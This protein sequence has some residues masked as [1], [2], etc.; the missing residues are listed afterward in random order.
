MKI[1][2]IL[3]LI[4][5]VLI[6]CKKEST[7]E[8]ML[9]EQPDAPLI[10][11]LRNGAFMPGPYGNVSGESK[12]YQTGMMYQLA[13]TNFLTSNGPDLKVYLSKELQ[14]V[15]FINLGSLKAISGNQLY[16]IP[17]GVNTAEYKY[18]LIY[19]QQYSHLFGSAELK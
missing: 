13:L 6:G 17:A 3:L 12:I 8:M 11:T 2:S 7:P 1:T 16:D 18:A 15:N 19:C 14:P 5:L 10:V 9:N 4:T